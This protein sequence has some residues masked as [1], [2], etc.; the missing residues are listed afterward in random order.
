[1]VR[2]TREQ[3]KA[4][5]RQRLVDEAR[6]LFKEQGYAATSLEQIAEAAEVTKGAIYGQFATKE[7]LLLSAIEMTPYPDYST[8]LNEQS[9]PLRERLGEFGRTVAFNEATS[10]TAELAAS[11]EFVA[12][13]LRNPEALQRYGV[14]FES[15]LNKLAADD[16]DV[17]LPGVT[18]L[19]VWAIGQALFVGLQL[20]HEIA[21]GIL[22][23]EVFGHAFELLTGL[24]PEPGPP[25]P[26]SGRE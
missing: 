11:L 24:Y 22:T 7:D 15:R 20:Y 21:P 19:Q 12:A 2:L 4:R 25:E 23:A 9:K 5:T 3:S 13:L 10:D 8:L 26:S 14:D 17:P 16:S 6:R 1:M 18:S